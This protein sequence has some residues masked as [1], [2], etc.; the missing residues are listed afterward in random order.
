MESRETF[1]RYESPF[2]I[3]NGISKRITRYSM[4][5]FPFLCQLIFNKWL[6][7]LEAWAVFNVV[8]KM[9][10]ILRSHTIFAHFN[11]Q[12][13]TQHR[14]W[15]R[16]RET[17]NISAITNRTYK[18]TAHS[19]ILRQFSYSY[20]VGCCVLFSSFL[21]LSSSSYIS[22]RA[23]LLLRCHTLF[24]FSFLFPLTFVRSFFPRLLNMV[25]R[26]TWEIVCQYMVFRWISFSLLL[27]WRKSKFSG[28]RFIHI[29]NIVS[30]FNS[31]LFSCS[32][33]PCVLIIIALL[34]SAL[35]LLL[36]CHFM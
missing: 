13:H 6:L 34:C 3:M 17:E 12:R 14:Q 16:E 5:F 26:K 29:D 1:L 19:E 32:I 11:T 20:L 7:F 21:L 9:A 10:A 30:S 27:L 8:D 18:F 33:I 36:F 35:S 2:H 25:E 4:H 28:I 15:E 24:P 23:L 31:L 22:S